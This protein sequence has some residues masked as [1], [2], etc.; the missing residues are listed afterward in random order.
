MIRTLITTNTVLMLNISYSAS[1]ILFLTY[2]IEASNLDMFNG[3]YWYAQVFTFAETRPFNQIFDL[4]GSE[5][6]NFMMNSASLPILFAVLFF[7]WIFVKLNLWVTIKLYRFKLC[8][9]YGM[10]LQK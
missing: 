1:L 3:P 5:D 8:R 9:K 10:S 6:M 4:F 7:Q 2:C